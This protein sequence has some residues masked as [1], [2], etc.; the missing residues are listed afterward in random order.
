[1]YIPK[2]KIAGS[3]GGSKFTFSV[4]TAVYIPM[5]SAQEFLFMDVKV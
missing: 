3:H 2:S 4:A 5:S 1:M